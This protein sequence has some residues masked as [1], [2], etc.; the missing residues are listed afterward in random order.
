MYI[1]GYGS[2]W[3]IIIPSGYGIQFWQTFIM[4]GAR[5]GG[6]RESEN[7]AFE[8]G[9]CYLPPDSSAGKEEEER[10]KNELKEKYFK[11]PPS[12]RVNYIK[13]G[14]KSPFYCPWQLLL[15]DWNSVEVEDFFVLRDMQLLEN[16]QVRSGLVFYYYVSHYIVFSIK[17]LMMKL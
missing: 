17:E 13:L 15:K 7:V 4:F 3:D 9:Q 5:S 2:G 10:I 16:I 11:L 14:I 6:L 8:M 12:K 1:L